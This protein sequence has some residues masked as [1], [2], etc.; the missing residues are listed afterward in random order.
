MYLHP[1]INFADTELSRNILCPHSAH[2]EQV[3]AIPVRFPQPLYLLIDT[4]FVECR[5]TFT[6][7]A[8]GMLVR[9][10][11]KLC[12]RS[13]PSLFQLVYRLVLNDREKVSLEGEVGS[14]AFPREPQPDKA[15]L[16]YILGQSS[17]AD[18]A[19]RELL[20][21]RAPPFGQYQ[22]RVLVAAFYALHKL[23]VARLL[24][25]GVTFFRFHYFNNRKREM[26]QVF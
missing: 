6:F 15:L 19:V 22:Q 20:C 18:K 14:V 10:C 3:E 2:C 24:V 26:L 5:E 17:I 23:A 21:G 13:Q 12:P 25:H 1:D 9:K 16:N 8:A 11:R 4:A 7:G